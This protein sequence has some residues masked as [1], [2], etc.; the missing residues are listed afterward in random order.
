MGK[1]YLN[2]AVKKIPWAKKKKNKKQKTKTK[3]WA[4]ITL[5]SFPGR[6]HFIHVI[7]IFGG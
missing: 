7:I 2:K 1:L 5:V 6:Q 3:P 4:L